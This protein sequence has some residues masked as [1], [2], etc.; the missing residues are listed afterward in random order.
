[1]TGRYPYNAG[2]MQYNHGV[3]EERSAVPA[4]F[5]MLPRLLKTA[6]Y[7]SHMLGKWHLVII[8]ANLT[9]TLQIW[10]KNIAMSPFFLLENSATF[11]RTGVL[12]AGP[13]ASR[14]RLATTQTCCCCCDY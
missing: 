8:H 12:H 2:L 9:L 13:H 6:G 5:D 7:K 1:M 14:T 4:A 11:A 10:R 3:E